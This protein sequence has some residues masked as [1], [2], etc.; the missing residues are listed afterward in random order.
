MIATRPSAQPDVLLRLAVRLARAA[1]TALLDMQAGTLQTRTKSSPS[2]VVSSADE[3]A[4]H[5][6]VSA[7]AA[8]RPGDG[9]VAE[10][11]TP[12]ASTSGITW[13]IDP[14]DG[15][16]NYLRGYPGW[17]VSI[18]ARDKD[19]PLAAVVHDPLGGVLYAAAKNQGSWRNGSRLRISGCE[20]LSIALV[21]TGLS[22]LPERRR[23]QSARLARL[24]CAV[25]DIRQGGSAALSLCSVAEGSVD[26]FVEDDLAPWDWAAGALLVAEAGGHIQVVTGHAGGSG[27]IAAS[28]RLLPLLHDAF[29]G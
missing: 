17:G 16:T 3:K 7:L 9:V 24:A 19:G 5:I 22:Y 14:L 29:L 10:E 8:C 26:A 1:G 20:D 11:S 2:D 18:C 4:Q 6:V 12:T 27:V 15:T 21:A 25:A 13:L 23:A 28:P